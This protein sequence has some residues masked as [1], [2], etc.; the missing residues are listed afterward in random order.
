MKAM[1]MILSLMIG[2]GANAKV[3]DFNAMI[4]ENVA[5]QKELYK[6]VKTRSDETRT[7]LNPTEPLDAS[8]V[9][10][11]TPQEAI[12]VPTNKDLLR[13]KKETVRHDAGRKSGEDRLASEFKSVDMAF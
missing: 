7:A 2:V 1:M 13:F 10:V 11:G 6:E 4:D 5:A 12:N 9:V 3:P 8:Q